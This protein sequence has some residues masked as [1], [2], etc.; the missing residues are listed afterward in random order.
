MNSLATFRAALRTT[1]RTYSIAPTPFRPYSTTP[2]PTPESSEQSASSSTSAAATTSSSSSSPAPPQA[3][4]AAIDAVL[5]S[6][7]ASGLT[8]GALPHATGPLG[9]AGH[10]GWRGHFTSSSSARS[11]P[12]SAP[13]TP[14]N[15]WRLAPVVNYSLPITTTTARS[16]PVRN[17]DVGRAYRLLNRTLQENNIRKELR[18]QE[19]FEGPSDK[20]VRLD[21]ERHRRRF[22]VAVGKAV[23]QA[24]RLKDL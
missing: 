3:K 20:R 21:S 15:N 18:R 11:A 14:E 23:S 1:S 12:A 13:P 9:A 8:P 22:K 24:M 7:E 2:S 10:S 4:S 17:M 5:Q 6:I 19:R 16:F